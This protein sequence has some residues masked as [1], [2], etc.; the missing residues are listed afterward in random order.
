MAFGLKYYGEFLDY[1]GNLVRCEILGK[2]FTG[3]ASEMEL[4]GDAIKLS[5]TTK[6]INEQICGM[7]VKIDVW[8][9]VDGQYLD[10]FS[11]SDKENMVVVYRA[12][13]VIFRGFIDPELYSEDFVA[14]PYKIT[15][16]ASDGL[17]LLEDYHPEIDYSQDRITLLESLRLALMQTG[18]ELPLLINCS[19]FP[20]SGRSGTLFDFVM[21]ETMTFRSY[22]NGAWEVTNSLQVITNILKSYSCRIYQ[23]NDCWYV[24]RVKN[25]CDDSWPRIKYKVGGGM[26]TVSA[27]ETIVV[28]TDNESYMNSP[29]TLERDSGYGK[30]TIKIDYQKLDTI[31]LNNPDVSFERWDSLNTMFDSE[32]KRWKYVVDESRPLYELIPFASNNRSEINVGIFQSYS[33]GTAVSP[34]RYFQKSRISHNED[35]GLSLSFKAASSART[36]L[37]VWFPEQLNIPIQVAVRPIEN[38][39]N[40]DTYYL[41][42]NDDGN[43]RWQKNNPA[44]IQ[45]K[46]S[47]DEWKEVEGSHT[48]ININV[49]FPDYDVVSYQDEIVLAVGMFTYPLGGVIIGHLAWSFVGDFSV[50]TNNDE[51]DNTF[52]ATVNTK[53]RRPAP[54]ISMSF[55]DIPQFIVRNRNGEI[56]YTGNNLNYNF[57]LFLGDGIDDYTKEWHDY[58]E[59]ITESNQLY[60]RLLIDNF[61]QYYDPREKLSGEILS[62][63]YFSPEKLYRVSGRDSKFYMMTG[64]D[65]NMATS[66]YKV[67]L[68]EIKKRQ[69]DINNG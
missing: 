67:Q 42:K 15:I 25:K 8:C 26:S 57:G 64:L 66:M 14:P 56:L 9:N 46:V 44:V 45:Y 6:D 59:N 53:Y 12:G 47:G 62:D 32:L 51:I 18:L 21:V 39:P 7:G 68:E 31:I 50:S 69:V 34:L 4:T 60:E 35:E 27:F 49:D 17:A 20:D 1:Y 24:D 55:Y 28:D 61:D 19:L 58:Q 23:A 13:Q 52:E 65:F 2:D 38:N 5:R 33:D 16:P 43:L 30:Q 22:V 41:S 37:G 63:I 36:N 48:S 11:T 3:M 10:L 29:A 40:N 54:D